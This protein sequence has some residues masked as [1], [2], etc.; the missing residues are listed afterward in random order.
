MERTRRPAGSGMQRGADERKSKKG[1]AQKVQNET[2]RENS[3]C[4]VPEEEQT[5]HR[6]AIREKIRE[7]AQGARW[8]GAAGRPAFSDGRRGE[9]A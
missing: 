2:Y 7:R 3:D 8:R 1:S 4:E 6:K 9:D 5:R